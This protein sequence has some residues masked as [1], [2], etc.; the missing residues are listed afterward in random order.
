MGTEKRAR[1]KAN[2]S[3]KL[4]AEAVQEKQDTRRRG[5]IGFGVVVIAV[6]VIVGLIYL[7][8]SDSDET[9]SGT[10]TTVAGAETTAPPS[11]AAALTPVEFTFG[12][13]EC[14]PADG[15]TKATL[16]FDA[17]PKNCLDEGKTYTA[18]FD[19]TAGNVVVELDTKDTPG[20]ANNFV[21]LSRHQYYD[22]TQL[23]RVNNGID[24]IQGGSPH[25]QSSADPGPGYSLK[26]EGEFN[27]DHSQGGYT[28]KAGD[29][30]MAR[31]SGP[32]GAGAQFF[33][34]TGKNG[35]GLDA[36]QP[37]PGAGTYVVFGHVTEGLEA[38]QKIV[39]TAEVDA[40]GEGKPN[41]EV[42]VKSVRITES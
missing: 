20:T 28:Y 2:R 36:G 26:D 31:T 4:Q 32:D 19:T 30:V 3:A 14:P 15:V 37:M 33:F 35:S 12:S 13:T 24:I 34:V 16:T 11:T 41:P 17:P 21:F 18:T 25:T 38:L 8:Q 27:E 10:T 23:F 5:V 40:S 29:L 1:Q 9:A 6:A 42:T 39:A 7:G 22:N